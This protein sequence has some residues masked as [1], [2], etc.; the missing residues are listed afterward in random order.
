[1]IYALRPADGQDDGHG[2]YK[3]VGTM[4]WKN[5]IGELLAKTALQVSAVDNKTTNE[6]M[7]VCLQCDKRDVEANRCKICK[8]YLAVK[9]NTAENL[10]PL[11]GRYEI[12]HCPLG[13]WNDL[14]IANEYRKI[15]GLPPL[16]H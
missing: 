5:K 15:D 4:N 11:K 16:S 9:T 14:E 12:T 13:K 1:M 2:K 7:A 3:I 8:C 10:N 6:R